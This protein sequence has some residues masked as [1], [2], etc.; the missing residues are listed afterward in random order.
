MHINWRIAKSYSGFILNYITGYKKGT[1]IFFYIT[2][3]LFCINWIITTSFYK[4]LNLH[5][6]LCH[7][8]REKIENK[9]I[10]TYS[11]FCVCGT[12]Y[13]DLFWKIYASI[14]TP[15]ILIKCVCVTGALLLIGLCSSRSTNWFRFNSIV[16]NEQ[17]LFAIRRTMDTL[18][19]NDNII[20]NKIYR[21]LKALTLNSVY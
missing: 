19:N 9:K 17:Y 5:I 10:T 11:N 1:E 3:C 8:C 12:K 13:R 21:A 15:A 16:T 6:S 18:I 2:P 7:I 20:T 14:S 4:K